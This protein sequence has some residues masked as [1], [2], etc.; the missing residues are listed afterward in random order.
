[1]SACGGS[2]C[3]I[4]KVREREKVA[5]LAAVE[6]AYPGGWQPAPQSGSPLSRVKIDSLAAALEDL[7]P[8][9]AFVRRAS[10]E[11][12][13]DWIYLL[14]GLHP[15][16]LFER[17]E[18]LVVGGEALRREETY[19]RI[20]FSRIGPQV[21]LQET[22]FRL[23]NDAEGALIEESPCL[24]VEDTRLQMLVK[25]TQGFLQKQ[26]LIT[27]DMAFLIAPIAEGGEPCWSYL[28][29]SSPP[30]TSRWVLLASPGID[31]PE[32]SAALSG[33]AGG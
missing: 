29:E 14:A 21:T 22:R 33:M 16:C 13:C 10:V 27:L 9:R 15:G 18:G 6:A 23:E 4:Q 32:P 31:A 25:G 30:T 26:R 28:F 17:A 5:V 11:G 2:A 19:L 1:M 12:D 3:G 20:G 24:G 7:L 8:V